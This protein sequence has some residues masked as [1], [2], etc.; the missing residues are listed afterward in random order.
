MHESVL[1]QRAVE[2]LV[3]DRDGLYIDGTFGRGGHSRAILQCLSD[4]GRLLV[5]DKDPAAIAVA[6]ALKEQDARVMIAHGSFASVKNLVQEQGWQG[7][8]GGILLD[9]G[10][11]S[12]QLDDKERGFSFL[13]DGPLDMR[14]NP[15]SGESAAEWI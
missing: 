12:P 9:L 13:H 15:L 3:V 2:Q 14:M 6:K 1:L 5:I 10:V 7:Q 4:Q 8:V 11:S